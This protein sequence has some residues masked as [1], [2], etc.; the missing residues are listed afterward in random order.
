MKELLLLNN[1]SKYLGMTVKCHLTSLIMAQLTRA[2]WFPLS[3][4][5]TY[6]VS[7]RNCR[8]F[9]NNEDMMSPYYIYL[10]PFPKIATLPYEPKEEK[11]LNSYTRIEVTAHIGLFTALHVLHAMMQRGLATINKAVC[12]S[13]YLSVCLS[14]RLSVKRVICDKTKESCAHI[15]RP[16]ER[17]FILVLETRRMA[18]RGRLLLPEILGQSGPVGAK[19]LIFNRFARSASAVTPS[20]KSSI[21]TNKKSTTSFPIEPKMNIVRC[22]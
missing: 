15:H 6:I 9:S 19:T 2:K 21:I 20:E 12:P 14:V 18:G 11:L 16:H 22:P 5:V 10:V 13:V 8:R 17:T 1:E 4:T 3:I 7:S